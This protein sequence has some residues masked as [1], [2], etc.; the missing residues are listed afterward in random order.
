MQTT[1]MVVQFTEAVVQLRQRLETHYGESPLTSRGDEAPPPSTARWLGNLQLE[2]LFEAEMGRLFYGRSL[3]TDP[4]T[5][6]PL[7]V[8]H[9]LQALPLTPDHQ[10]EV[11]E[12]VKQ[13]VRHRCQLILDHYP[14]QAFIT[15]WMRPHAIAIFRIVT[16]HQCAAVEGT[17]IVAGVVVD[18]V[19]QHPG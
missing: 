9:I 3:L 19:A 18:P 4:T 7:E 12:F 14:A 16:G 15:F 10:F 2:D 6:A 11:A 1:E 13:T 17:P 5:G 8:S